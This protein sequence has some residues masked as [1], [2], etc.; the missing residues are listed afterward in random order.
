M[1]HLMFAL[2]YILNNLIRSSKSPTLVE[3][4]LVE[5]EENKKLRDKEEEELKVET[6]D[7]ET[8]TDFDDVDEFTNSEPE[9]KLVGIL[10]S[11]LTESNGSQTVKFSLNQTND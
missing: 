1:L 11:V 5:L 6:E 3:M 2:H 7:K 9:N 4:C 10:H 8:E